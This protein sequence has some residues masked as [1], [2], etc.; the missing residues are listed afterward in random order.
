MIKFFGEGIHLISKEKFKVCFQ[1]T[2]RKI[3]VKILDEK[4]MKIKEG[5]KRDI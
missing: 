4:I 2:F 1:K 3:Y 5:K